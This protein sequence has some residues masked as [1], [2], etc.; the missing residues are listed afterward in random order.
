[1]EDLDILDCVYFDKNRNL[2][3]YSIDYDR[4]FYSSKEIES[5]ERFAAVLNELYNDLP[6]EFNELKKICL[7]FCKEQLTDFPNVYLNQ[8]IVRDIVLEFFYISKVA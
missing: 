2:F 7:I 3:R 1:M 5:I 4:F 6:V 8:H